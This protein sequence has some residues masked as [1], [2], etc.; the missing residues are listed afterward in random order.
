[1]LKL[2]PLPPSDAPLSVKEAA[3]VLGRSETWIRDHLA[4]GLL[5][6]DGSISGRIMVS[7]VSVAWAETLG[8]PRR[9][10]QLRLVVDNTGCRN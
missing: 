7:A 1:M 5:E 4:T 2:M 10:P 6:R 3:K 9:A 8:R